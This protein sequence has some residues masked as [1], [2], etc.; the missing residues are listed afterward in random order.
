MSHAVSSNLCNWNWGYYICAENVYHKHDIIY[1]FQPHPSV[2]QCI[3]NQFLTLTWL[4]KTHRMCTN[5]AVCQGWFRCLNAHPALPLNKFQFWLK[6][7]SVS[8]SVHCSVSFLRFSCCKYGIHAWMQYSNLDQILVKNLLCTAAAKLSMSASS[9][10]KPV[11]SWTPG[12]CSG[13]QWMI[14][15]MQWWIGLYLLQSASELD[16]DSLWA[17]YL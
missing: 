16:T 3:R 10:G 17:T 9:A 1:K 8:C 2:L 7:S 6:V 11:V 5:G 4:Y 14:D 15:C 13:Q 12:L